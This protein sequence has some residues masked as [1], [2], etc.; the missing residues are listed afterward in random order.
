MKRFKQIEESKEMIAD[1]FIGLLKSKRMED[2]TVSQIA[3]EAKIGRN[4]FYNHFRTK[5]D[6]LR[7]V[8]EKL[9]QDVNNVLSAKPDPS[10]REFLLW[11]FSLIKQNPQLHVFKEEQNIQMMLFQFRRSHTALFD[12]RLKV[13][14]YTSEFFFGGIDCLTARWIRNGMKESPEEMTRKV[15]SL[16]GEVIFQADKSRRINVL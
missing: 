3:S 6:I 13:D 7:Y 4:T 12:P 1:A 5:E 14:E 9:F 2:I 15:L 10:L 16:P 11:R 8:F